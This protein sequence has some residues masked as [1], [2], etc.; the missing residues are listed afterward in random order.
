MPKLRSAERTDANSIWVPSTPLSHMRQ[1]DALRAL[2]VLA[3][4]LSHFTL[5]TR[6]VWGA[7]QIVDLAGFGV[8]LF[9]V[10]SGFLITGILLR[11]KDYCE[12]GQSSAGY[13]LRQFYARRLLR[14]FPLFYLVLA[15]AAF[16]AI[17]PVRESWPWHVSYLTNFLLFS[18]GWDGAINHFW[19]LAIEE[20]F[21][22]VWPWVI[23]LADRRK[24]PGLILAT[25]TIGPVFRLLCG[26]LTS[27]DRTPILPFSCL[28]TLGVGALLAF[29]NSLPRSEASRRYPLGKL[30]LY[31]GLILIASFLLLAGL[32][33]GRLFQTVVFDMGAALT[34]GWIVWSASFGFSG[35]LGKFLESKLLIY[36][37]TIS[38]G[39][40]VYHNFMGDLLYHTL[41]LPQ[42]AMRLRRPFGWMCDSVAMCGA[43]IFIAALSWHCFEAPL[44]RLK[45]YFKYRADRPGEA[46]A[47][48]RRE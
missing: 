38:Y 40:Y 17:A 45:R 28:D 47:L 31:S 3:V 43:T 12:N 29:Y 23:L 26:F 30:G 7:I 36:L 6:R 13:E 11:A 5:F 1:L 8:R 20:Q 24:L 9:F 15:L 48:Q 41:N 19:S 33:R 2:A 35:W 46:S 16:L 32:N 39:I 44:N 14:I 22:L 21:Y 4:L 37:G 18:R 10:L 27:N 34:C 25:I 42:L